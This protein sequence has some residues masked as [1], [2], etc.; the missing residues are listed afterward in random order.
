MNQNLVEMLPARILA[1]DDER[2]IHAALRLRLSREHQLVCCV[3]A[4]EALEV[5]SQDRFDLCLVDIHMPEMD[6]LVFVECA[7]RLDPDLGFVVVSAFDSDENLRRAIP[8][9]VLE[10]ISK[11]LPERDVFDTRILLWIGETRRRR[12]ERS[13]AQRATSAVSDLDTALIERE[14]E[15]VA[16]ESA[17]DA[18]LQISG[19]LTTIHAHVAAACSLATSRARIDS[20]VA[21]LLRNLEEARKTAAAAMTTAAGF[22]DSAYGSR[23]SSPAVFSEGVRR[24]IEIAARTNV[25]NNANKEAEFQDLAIPVSIKGI[26]GIDFLLMIVPVFTVA[27]SIAEANSTFGIQGEHCSRLDSVSRDPRFADYYW[28]NRRNV[29][30]SHSCVL[31]FVSVNAPALSRTQIEDWF[32]G[33]YEPLAFITARG[34]LGGIRKCR[35]LLGFSVAPR[36]E[37][38]RMLLAL[39]I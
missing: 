28:I 3:S 21:Q 19:L 33:E 9:Q 38:F 20:S 6:G 14:V 29:L 30:G 26:S 13:L 4:E 32:K 39:P 25:A 34:V 24:A 2:Q 12:Q 27:F 1:V 8:L 31:I 18:L 35:G 5:L 37:K 16:S 22:F 23:D 15:V 10:F 7:R 36:A 11:P 17:R